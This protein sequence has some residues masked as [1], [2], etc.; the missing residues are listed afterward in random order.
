MARSFSSYGSG[1]SPK[2]GLV[3]RFTMPQFSGSG[4]RAGNAAGIVNLGSTYGAL[5]RSKTKY[6]SISAN[7]IASR[8]SQ[9]ATA[10]SAR[11]SV[12]ASKAV[13][14]GR[15]KAAKIQA[16]AQKS[17][18]KSKARGSM[19]GSAFKAIG[20]IGGLALMASDES[21]KDNIQ[22]IDDALTKLRALKPVTFNY[23]EE[24]ST[25]PEILHH[26][27]IAQDYMKVMPDATYYDESS[28]KYCIDTSELI[29]LLVRAI[30]QLE[31]KV[32][33]LEVKHALAGVK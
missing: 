6:S 12:D 23:K 1:F 22:T 11:A 2:S 19:W 20:T 30:Q 17:A 18:A 8:A 21:I 28:G 31:V 27:F 29:G 4:S 33:S 14:K 32:T 9:R 15:L 3:G 7:A 25:N 26:G 16:S 10:I 24:W 5:R 13:N